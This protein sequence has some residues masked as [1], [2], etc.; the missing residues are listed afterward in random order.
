MSDLPM[1]FAD[2]GE[3]QDGKMRA[4]VSS[5]LGKSPE[6]YSISEGFQAT[7]ELIYQVV[8]T[9]APWRMTA[10]GYRALSM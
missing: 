3:I 2:H 9:L 7:Y 5:S 6:E 10:Q 4:V 8:R 1:T